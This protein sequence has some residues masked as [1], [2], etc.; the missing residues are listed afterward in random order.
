[1]HKHNKHQKSYDFSALVKA[2]SSLHPFV[3]TNKHNTKTID[4]A[5]AEA[6][7]QLNKAIL[8]SDYELIDYQLPQGYLCPPIPGRA[9]YI[10]HLAD[11][12]QKMDSQ[13][14]GLDIGIGANGI[15]PILAS[16]IY[17]WKMV[18]CD[19]NLDAVKISRHNVSLND[20]LSENIDIRLQENPA[21]IF[22]NIIKPNEY[23]HFTMCNPP[24][25]ASA[26]EA[27]KGTQRKWSNL[28]GESSSELNFGGQAHELWCNGGE[29]LF[30]KRMIKESAQFKAQVGWF[31]TL[32]AKG[33]HLPKLI[34]QLDKLKATYK[35]INMAQGQKQS[36]ILAWRFE[37]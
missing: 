28:T 16:Q 14:T 5:N 23:Y 30:I 22:K 1:M 34:K 29:A 12:L 27:Q 24:F 13:I 33:S 19:I 4:F 21:H 15:Y 11:L 32:V 35:I 36:R 20:S 10:H 6:V 2:N 26:I 9:D 17:D 7:Y 31:T 18:G 8:I 3:F 37:D 25:H